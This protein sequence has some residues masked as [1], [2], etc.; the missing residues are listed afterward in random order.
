MSRR[1]NIWYSLDWYTVALYLVLVFCGWISIYAA[2]FDFDA[3]STI[4]SFDT[5]SGKQLLWIL[6]SLVI[7]FF[8]L[9]TEPR[10][11]VSLSYPL[12]IV[13][14]VL[15]IVTIFVAPDIK[16]SHSWIVLGPVHLQPA[17]FA[18]YGTAL[19][20][21]KMLDDYDFDLKKPGCF[22]KACALILLPVVFI[23]MQQETGS[24]L[25]YLALICILY[26]EGMSSLF[27]FAA[28]CAIVYFVL[29]VKF[30]SVEWLATPV[31][32]WLVLTLILWVLAYMVSAYLRNSRFFYISLLATLVF[33]GI[34]LIVSYYFHEFNLLYIA[35][36]LLV[37]AVLTAAGLYFK[38][39]ERRLWIAVV[40]ALLSC[41][42]LESVEYAFTR[43]LEPHQRTRI[44]VALGITED[45]MGVGYNVNQSKI[46]IGSGGFAGKGFLN[47]TQTK[48]RYV[49]EQDTDFIFC[50]IG[51]EQGFVGT[52]G[53][54]LLF[55][56]LLVRIIQLAERQRS[57]FG[58]VYGYCVAAIIFFHLA[59]N[60]GMVIGVLPV[61]GIPLP[62]FSYGGSSLWGFTIL[63]FTLL[64]I[65]ASRND[66][67]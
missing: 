44:E 56:L 63:L 57:V 2:S 45:P 65:D 30:A 14:I 66:T 1:N 8:I 54:L 49:P 46:A 15:L 39:L 11:F 55:G 5:R 50:T 60:I 42:F 61:I 27:L 22:F 18:K 38:T 35:W 32:E 12:Y 36:P 64:C 4:F 51:E 26:R 67:L 43:V 58:R 25:V 28:L 31:G 9:M 47:G 29:A 7:G 6:L 24:A 33:E 10:T 41:F 21:A 62:F 16:G 17:E 52:V 20:L 48:L 3:A 19:A 13:F 34:G 23:L 59:V 40:F 53:I 37:I